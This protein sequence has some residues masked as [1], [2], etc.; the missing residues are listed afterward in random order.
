MHPRCKI[1]YLRLV[2]KQPSIP[3]TPYVVPV[4]SLI[5]KFVNYFQINIFQF[6]L[7]L[8]ASCAIFQV[9]T[10]KL[11]LSLLIIVSFLVK[12]KNKKKESFKRKFQELFYCRSPNFRTS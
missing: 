7:F 10:D 5:N 8:F 12:G 2:H 6:S 11:T 1:V 9:P 3:L 4:F